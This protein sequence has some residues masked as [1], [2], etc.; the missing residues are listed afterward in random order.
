[1]KAQLRA[2]TGS[3]ALC[4]GHGRQAR[5][6]RIFWN[7]KLRAPVCFNPPAA[8][9][10][11]PIVIRKTEFILEGKSKDQMFDSTRAAFDKKELPLPE[12]NSMCY[13]MSS[14]GYLSDANGR[15]H[16][17]L[18][19]FVRLVDPNTWGAGMPDSPIIGFKDVDDRLTLFLIPVGK[20][21]DGTLAPPM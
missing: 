13:V 5:T 16:S 6:T 11:L 1:M 7:P 14:Q 21:S 2:R 15:W 19:F 9:S 4:N 3:S 17:H 12:P 10:N 20:W 18:M 8:R